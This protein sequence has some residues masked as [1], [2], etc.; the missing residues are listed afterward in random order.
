VGATTVF[1]ELQNSLDHIWRAPERN[2]SSGLWNFLRVRLLSLGL[3]LGVGFLLLVSLVLSALLAA[4]GRWWAPW[5]GELVVVASVFNF[6]LSMVFITVLFAM[7][8][9]WMPSTPVAWRHV[10][11]GAVI[12][13][14]LFVIGKFLIGQFLGRS[15]MAS[16]FGAA[17]SLVLLLMWVYY[18]ALIFLFGAE[19]TWV[20]ARQNASL[21]KGDRGQAA[22]VQQ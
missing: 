22:G 9:K 7:I 5:F 12:T 21:A 8:Y 16:A 2:Q 4:L 10:W 11:L 13:A 3:I 17:S 15:A 20:I 6:V 19:F 14:L 1:A 18:S